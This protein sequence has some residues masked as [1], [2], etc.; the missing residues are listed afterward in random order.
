MSLIKYFYNL[1]SLPYFERI[2]VR[3]IP[4]IGGLS[5]ALLILGSILGLYYVPA[6]YQQHDA[7]RIMY[8]HVPSA[9]LSLAI[10]SFIFV[11]SCCF[12]IWRIKLSDILAESSAMIGA[13]FTLIA[14]ITGSIWGK[15][16]WGTW[17]VWDARLTSELILFFLYLGYMGL[18]AAIRD[19]EQAAKLCAVLSIVGMIDI[20]IIHFSVEWWT[21]LHQGASISKFSKPSIAAEMLYPL[22]IMLLGFA[23]F[24]I[25]IVLLRSGAKIQSIQ[26]RSAKFHETHY[27][28]RENYTGE[29]YNGENYGNLR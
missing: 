14:L 2:A 6:D 29:N 28:N 17:W 15:P 9:F 23:L 19:S 4:W 18:R 20:P 1:A 3:F 26:N 22:L 10:F 5:F 16:M 24:Y 8:V 25:L 21:T 13:S 11:Q 27:S 12:L 7:F